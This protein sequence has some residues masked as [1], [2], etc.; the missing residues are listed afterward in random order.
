M[1][2][3]ERQLWAT[4]YKRA[5][6]VDEAGRGPLA[7]P[8]VAAAVVFNPAFIEKEVNDLFKSLT[9]SKK[10]SEN[11]RKCFFKILI[12]SSE[13][14]I[15]IG[16]GQVSEIDE[17]NILKATHHTM[18]RAL[19]QLPSLPDYAIIDG[20]PVPDLPCPSTAVVGGDAKSI[21]VAAASVIAKVTRDEWMKEL[22]QQ[23]PAYGFCHHKG[24]GTNAH[25]H[26]LLKYGATTQHRRSFRPVRDI[27]DIRQRLNRTNEHVPVKQNGMDAAIPKTTT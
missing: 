2:R 24:Y 3:I 13:V 4:G 5:A 11:Q 8:V 22:D 10:L 27:E 7:G 16:F 12:E 21:S 6:G 1:L 26:A 9:D 25:I 17:V 19:K 23:H 18:I 20:L 14:E 15:G